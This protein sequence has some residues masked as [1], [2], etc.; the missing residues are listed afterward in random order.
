MH[1]FAAKNNTYFFVMCALLNLYKKM[2]YP[3]IKICEINKNHR[4][5][6]HNLKKLKLASRTIHMHLFIF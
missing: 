3:K 2:R 6:S 4:K 1:K 5:L